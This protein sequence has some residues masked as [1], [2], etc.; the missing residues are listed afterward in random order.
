MTATSDASFSPELFRFFRDLAKHNNRAWFQSNKPRYESAVLEPAV[1]F[2]RDVAPGV[3]RM[4]PQ[5][6][7]DARP[8]G[9]AVSRIYRDV[10][11]S[12][13]KSPY[14]TN[15]GI[16]FAHSDAESSE[17][18]LPGLYLHLE[19]GESMVGAGVWR[20]SPIGLQ[21]IRDGIVA[22]PNA[23]SRATRATPLT[24]GESYVRVPTGYDAGHRFAEDL[25]RKDFVTSVKFSDAEV[26]SPS[27]RKKFLGAARRTDPLN[28]F[29]AGPLGV[30]W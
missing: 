29:L 20:P 6:I 12:K 15:V 27:F 5:M 23:W 18:H 10:R 19:P 8:Y 1:Q 4:S 22:D 2:V 16:H 17:E 24:S 3:A 25:R 28:Q 7:A 9:G 13:D 14:R 30:P 26:T 11:F 21:R